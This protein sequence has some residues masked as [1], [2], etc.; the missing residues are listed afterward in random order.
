LIW[1]AMMS[2]GSTCSSGKVA[3]SHVLTA[4]GVE[5]KLAACALRA[6][7]A[8]PPAWKTSRRRFNR[9]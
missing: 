4:M 3:V 5:D 7:S 8:G 1:T 2:S 6:S 9:C